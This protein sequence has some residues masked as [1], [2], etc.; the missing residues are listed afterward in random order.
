MKLSLVAICLLYVAPA[1]CFA[2]P[3]PKLNVNIDPEPI[4]D[5]AGQPVT[6]YAGILEEATPAVVSIYTSRIQLLS[7]GGGDPYREYLRRYFGIPVPQ[8]QGMPEQ[9]RETLVPV[10]VGSGV[11]VSE[12]GYIITNH[13]VVSIQRDQLADEIRV[14]LSD[15]REFVAEFVGSDQKTDVA[16]LKIV[17][18]APLPAVKLADSDKLRVGD[19]VFAIGNPLNV[20]M[21]ATQGIVSATGRTS[22]GILGPGGYENFIQ[23]DA[24]I[25]RGN[26][27]GALVDAWGRLI[28]INTAIA[29]ATG[30]NLGIGFSI[31][32]NMAMNIAKS[33]V[34]LGEVPRGLL[35]LLPSNLDADQAAAF[36]LKSTRGAL[37]ND[38]Q[39]GGPA[40]KAGIRHGD[41][42]V[43]V[44]KTEIESA[45]QLR[46]VVSQ[47][48]PGTKV[49][50]KLIRRGKSLTL[51][52]VLGS[53]NGTVVRSPSSLPMEKRQDI[54]EGVGIEALTDRIR[55]E[56]SIPPE[57]KGVVI[58]EVMFE[59][60]YVETLLE[61]MVIVEVNGESVESVEELKD[62]LKEGAN[63]LYTWVEGAKRFTAIRIKEKDNE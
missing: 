40:D 5:M 39:E 3:A 4:K 45:E 9:Q 60:P 41:V 15:D 62:L 21:T 34:E 51:P 7:Q 16:V 35:G 44:G 53:L 26:S 61:N 23:T 47:I 55:E 29:S 63:D 57:I 25:N 33:L 38:V 30:E 14:R 54:L 36:G 6:S 52:V 18:E 10:G 28:G 2:E 59:S 50:V 20:G 37:V 8:G 17:S 48:L 11:I 24:A 22:F 31:P 42:I 56:L 46:V 32:V 58:R 27:G 19:I 49:S 1:F 43:R 12:D 13:H